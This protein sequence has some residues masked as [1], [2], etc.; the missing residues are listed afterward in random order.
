MYACSYY[1]SFVLYFSIIGPH[2][3]TKLWQQLRKM[4]DKLCSGMR[5]SSPSVERR[6]SRFERCVV[7][8]TPTIQHRHTVPI[9]R[10]T[11]VFYVSYRGT[12]LGSMLPLPRLSQTVIK[13][14]NIYFHAFYSVYLRLVKFNK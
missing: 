2:R 4:P 3:R 9:V 8:R 10:G 7:I 6:I 1:L 14:L 13:N 5:R 12:H 11:P